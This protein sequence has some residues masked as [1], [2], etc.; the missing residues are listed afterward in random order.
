[1]ASSTYRTADDGLAGLVF[2]WTSEATMYRF[3]CS[4]A[5]TGTRRAHVRPIAL[6]CARSYQFHL[7]LSTEF[8]VQQAASLQ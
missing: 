8:A 7:G 5:V 2:R 3:V 6:P 1:V 4:A